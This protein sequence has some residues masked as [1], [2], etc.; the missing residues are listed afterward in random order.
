MKEKLIVRVT[1]DQQV[2]GV[3]RD[4]VLFVHFLRQ[5]DFGAKI[6]ELTDEQL[7][8]SA[9]NYWSSEYGEYI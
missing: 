8:K 2:T 6:E 5:N 4:L 3:I 1:V 9:K 7:V